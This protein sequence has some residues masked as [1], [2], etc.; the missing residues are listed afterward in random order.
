MKQSTRKTPLAIA[1]AAASLTM[2]VTL[3]STAF[4]QASDESTIEELVVTGSYRASLANALDQKRDSANVKESIVAEDI[5]KM[6]DL[7]L[8]ESLQRVPGV[9]ITREGGEGRQVSVRGL[10]ADFSRTTLN[11]MEVPASGGGIDS[12]GGINR[13][14]AV[15]FNI[16]ASELFSRIDIHK[17][18]VAAVEEGGLA[19]TIELHT[20]KPLDNPGF[21]AVVGAQGTIDS[22]AD[23]FDPR[24][25]ALIS[26]TFLD[27]RLGV[28]F[29]VAKSERTVKQEG[30]GSVR[31]AS[32]ATENRSW[33]S[34]ANTVVNGTPN[35]AATLSDASLP[36]PTDPN[37]S[38]YNAADP[39]GLRYMWMPRLPR[40]DH[41]SN[42]V[43][44]TGIT[45]GIQFRPNDKLEL[46]VDVVTSTLENDRISYNYAAQFRNEWQNVTPTEITL[47]P[48][49]RYIVKGT[50]E[51]V[52][53]RSE[54]R[55]QYSE[56]DFLQT[57][58]NGTYNFTD[59]VRLKGLLGRATSEHKEEQYR[60]NID[61]PVGGSTFNFDATN[62]NIAAMSYGF[63]MLNP[64]NYTVGGGLTIRKDVIDRTNDTAR[65]DLEIDGDRFNT[66]LGIIS[67]TREVDSLS[68][69]PVGLTTPAANTPVGNFPGMATTFKSQVGGSFASALNP[70]A[71]FP[72]DWMVQDFNVAIKAHNAGNFEPSPTNTLTWNVEEA[73]VGIYG[74]VDTE[75]DLAGKPLYVNAGVRVVETDTTATANTLVNGVVAPIEAEGNYRDTLPSL[76]LTWALRDDLL[77]RLGVAKNITRPSLGSL[78]PAITAVTPVNGNISGGN[79][80]LK[81]VSANSADV[82][83]EWYFNDESLLALTVFRKEIKGFIAQQTV[84]GTLN[85]AIAAVVA[86]RPEYDPSSPL[87][88]PN[89]TQP[90]GTWSV[91]RPE[92]S[93]DADLTGYEI[94]YQQP[95]SFLPG[96]WSNFGVTANFTHVESEATFGRTVSSLP[97]LSEDSYNFTAYY[98]TDKW[99]TRLSWNNRDDYVTATSG[100][101]GN[102]R[103]FNTGPTRLD[104]SAFYNLTDNV[105]IRLEAV[106]LM[107]EE[108]R[109]YTTG[110]TGDLDFVR[111]FNSTGREVYLGIRATF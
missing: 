71:G 81:A 42:T 82:S 105:T 58:F 15:D 21:K 90:N 109:S 98:E 60:F 41:F 110:P 26:N 96:F 54:S 17:T 73:T 68:F 48:T 95:F 55:A 8:S 43:D 2:A 107:E 31:Y 85:P 46:G 51:G 34:V 47:D 61:G 13:G 38:N 1:V 44:R 50:F 39:D 111:E 4:A 69:N 91:S 94:T 18:P 88:D 83:L 108:E 74:Q 10:G 12:S 37:S 19:S 103:E 97:G 32:A 64:D 99:G 6:P 79:P 28:I 102:A 70:P 52:R 3:P 14:R 75:F 20:A 93:Q 77:L 5:G 49:G 84:S 24:F 7:N 62:P 22:T 101:N 27:D 29:S 11:G 67:N 78:V 16:F 106:N 92:N 59:N 40:M 35:A 66:K 25:T 100:S 87:Y 76:N 9:A 86:L 23:E 89:V 45:G 56:T 33:K 72:R 80:D 104:L 53:P 63:D 30:Y 57:V 65:L 36:D